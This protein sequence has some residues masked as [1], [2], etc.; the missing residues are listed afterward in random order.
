[1]IKHLLVILFIATS[2][3]VFGQTTDFTFQGGSSN[4]L[5]A[6]IQFTQ[7]SSG[8]PVGYLWDFGNGTR[9]NMANPVATYTSPGTYA[10]RLITVYANN[11]AQKTKNVVIHPS[12]TA[13]FNYDRGYMCQPGLV[14]FT[15]SSSGSLEHYDWD[16]GD[17]SAHVTGSANTISH[18]YT[19]FGEFTVTFT[20]TSTTG[21]SVSATRVVKVIKPGITGSITTAMTGCVPM[22]TDF[23]ATVTV[24]ASVTISNYLWNFGDAGSITTTLPLVSHNYIQVGS[25]SPSVTVTTSEGCTNT[26]RYD[27]LFFGRPPTNEIAYALDTVYCGSEIAQFV[28]IATDANRY[29]WNFEGGNSINSVTDTLAH[30]KYTSLG[31]KP[32]SVTPVFNGCPGTTVNFQIEIIGVIAK[33]KYANTCNDRK[34]FLFDNTSVGHIS[35][36]N[37]SLG[38]QAYSTNP[39][40][41]S[42][43]Y[44]QQ[45]TFGVKLLITD[46]ITGC[47]DSFKAKIYTANPVMKNNDQSICI[48]SDSHFSI[49]NNYTNPGLVYTWNALGQDIGPTADAAP[50]VHADSLGHFSSQVILDNGH[51]Y[52]PDTIHL[53]H[54]ITVRGPQLNFTAPESQCLNLPLSV[55]NLSHPFQPSDSVHLWYWNFGRVERNDT[56]FQP[57]P[58]T[59]VVPRSYRVKLVAVD[60]TGCMDSLVK[61]VT[62]R[63]MPFLW[64]IPK[65]DTLCEG[66]NTTLIGYTSDDILWTPGTGSL[67]STCDTT[68]MSPLNTTRYY[69][70]A[71][72]SFN[73]VATDSA[74]VRVFNPFRAAPLTPDTS[75]CGGGN[76]QLDVEPRGKVIS[77]SPPAGLSNVN[78]YNPVASPKQTTTYQ[79][80]LTDSAGCFTSNT[81]IKLIVKSTPV[82][83]AGPDK[84][85][86]YGS[87]FTLAPIYSSNIRTWLWTPADSLS[88]AACPNPEAVAIRT[89]T[90]AVKVISDSGCIA[91]D[92]ITVFVECNGANLFLPNA[93]TPN[94]DGRNDIYRPITRGIKY[95]KK[96]VIFNREGQLVYELSDYVPN[97]ENLGW[98]GKFKG[99]DQGPAAFVYMIEAICDI[100]ETITSKGSFILIR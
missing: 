25:F 26:F 8:S 15:A 52:C 54:M 29:D 77:W 40:T 12:I 55:V 80:T 28:G 68:T 84:V 7:T 48:N 10:V 63:P 1:M 38:N 24:P 42:H 81:S 91:Q 60:V 75:F 61:K 14:N 36:T 71:T 73:C 6:E 4:C 31:V 64:I 86:P 35:T 83:D 20:A 79:A 90:Y 11:T 43:T 56:T 69:A 33:F 66:Q 18:N 58:Y 5:P 82:L 97:K 49:T 94:H 30:H 27:S 51:Q 92:R 74:L 37:W 53:D 70:T 41:V 100:G 44:P 65:F 19:N 62:M 87:T 59:Y 93:F 9:S 98:D 88:C 21:C 3:F 47:V 96:F 22:N 16:F 39:D 76:I 57:Q 23:R 89:K 85:Y 67:C 95:I 72:N 99:K 32:V 78:I 50:I 46:N 45:G 34:T 2:Q 17:G 13:N